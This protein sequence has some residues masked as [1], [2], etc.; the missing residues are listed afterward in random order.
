[1]AVIWHREGVKGLQKQIHQ[2]SSL[3][4]LVNVMKLRSICPI[5]PFAL[6]GFKARLDPVLPWLSS[7]CLAVAELYSPLFTACKWEAPSGSVSLRTNSKTVLV[8]TGRK[9]KWIVQSKAKQH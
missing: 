8:Y 7:S 3:T 6:G 9:V 4:E 2:P 1:M 5:D